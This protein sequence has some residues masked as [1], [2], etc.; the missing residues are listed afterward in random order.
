MRM[1]DDDWQQVI[2]VNMSADAVGKPFSIAP[3]IYY[4][5][6]DKLSVGLTHDTGLCLAG[7]ENGCADRHASSFCL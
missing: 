6:S 5:V 7:E 1:K 2:D 4:G 3:D